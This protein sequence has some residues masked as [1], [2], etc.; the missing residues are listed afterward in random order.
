MNEKIQKTTIKGIVLRDNKVLL[1]KDT[2]GVW[3]LPG[4][5]IEF[6]ENPKDTLKRE[7]REEL[8]WNDLKVDKVIDVWDFCSNV[9]QVDYHFIVVVFACDSSETKIV[10]DEESV[11]YKWIPVS[12]INDLNMKDG[13][14]KAI[15][16]YL[17]NN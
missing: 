13:Y 16:K 10:I 7:F 14:K 4:E 11:E 2:K 12:E 6:G 9:N 17:E 8:G 5:K 15:N 3:E 1:V